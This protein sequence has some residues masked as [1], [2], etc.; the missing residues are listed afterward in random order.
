M[1]NTLSTHFFVLSHDMLIMVSLKYVENVLIY[2]KTVGI[3]S[4][5]FK[6]TEIHLYSRTSGSILTILAMKIMIKD[7]IK[8]PFKPVVLWYPRLLCVLYFLF[9]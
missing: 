5:N 1:N 4:A 2:S 6:I 3:Y 8:N 9:S 7:K